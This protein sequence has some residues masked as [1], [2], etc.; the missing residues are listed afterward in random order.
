MSKVLDCNNDELQTNKKE[1]CR[2]RKMT[3]ISMDLSKQQQDKQTTTTRKTL[4][5]PGSHQTFLSRGYVSESPLEYDHS[6]QVSNNNPVLYIQSFST[7]S[8]SGAFHTSTRETARG[9]NFSFPI[10][11][12]GGCR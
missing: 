10:L 8:P 12:Q 2:L 3:Q 9:K 11:L 5:D 1:H 4:L 6:C 7:S